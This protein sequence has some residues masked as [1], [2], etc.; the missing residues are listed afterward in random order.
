VSLLIA[1]L[2]QGLPVIR[3]QVLLANKLSFS[4]SAC[5]LYI[6]NLVSALVPMRLGE[7]VRIGIIHRSDGISLSET[8]LTVIAG[9][10]LDVLSLLVLGLVLIFI[11]PLPPQLLQ[12]TA[13][14][15]AL[16]AGAL[17][18]LLLVLRVSQRLQGLHQRLSD[19]PIYA[20]LFNSVRQA[21]A[22][23]LVIREPGRLA[24]IVGLSLGFWLVTTLAGSVLLLS[25]TQE[26]IIVLSVM[27]TFSAGI[28]RLLPGLP[29]GI[30]TVD[31]AVLV[32]LTS[33]GVSRDDALAL[34]LL[35]RARYI[36]MT[37]ITAVYGLLLLRRVGEHRI[38]R[39]GVSDPG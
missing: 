3:W 34:V 4:S 6:G 31:A 20:M 36:L 5:A 21:W 8:T 11:A 30:G 28:G 9:H 25:L 12:A 18:G 10:V 16:A 15:A 23:L 29:G 7:I 37:G 14:L 32:G 38:F 17:L 27:L 39:F 24:Q 35:L 26:N 13:L 19:K 1:V 22:S 2:S 33:L